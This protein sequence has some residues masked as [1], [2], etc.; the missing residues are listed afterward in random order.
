MKHANTR[1]LIRLPRHCVSPRQVARAGDIWRLCQEAA[2]RASA[3]AGWSGARFVEERV[4]FIVSRMTVVHDRE[5]VYGTPIEASTWIRDWRRDTLSRREVR[6]FSDEASV[7]RATQQWVHVALQGDGI[8]PVRASPALLAAFPAQTIEHATVQLPTV[9]QALAGNTHEFTFDVW[10]TWMDPFAHVNHPVYV[11]WADE[12]IAR[13][14]VAAGLNPQHVVPIAEQVRF[15]RGLVGGQ[16]VKLHTQIQGLT[17]Q[18][19]VVLRHRID[20]TD[21]QSAADVITVRRML[22]DQPDWLAVFS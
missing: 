8:A 13:R 22:D 19:D 10:H 18:G 16:A 4:G 5:L 3:E 14:L 20:T 15:K 7:A 9:V 6:L 1:Y 11:D 17:E 2:V 12:A 21:G